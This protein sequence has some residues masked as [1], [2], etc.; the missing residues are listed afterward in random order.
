[1][2]ISVIQYNQI[3]ENERA[4]VIVDAAA[5]PLILQNNISRGL[6]EGILVKKEA[7]G[8]VKENKIQENEGLL[9][10]AILRI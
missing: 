7:K 1:M 4:G 3:S 8:T 9:L 5:N 2:V 6:A 10:S